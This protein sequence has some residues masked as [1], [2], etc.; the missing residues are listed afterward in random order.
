VTNWTI[1]KSDH[2]AVILTTEHKDKATTKNEHIK[3][4]N[5][6]VTNTEL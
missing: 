6:I 4:D 5:T 1:T 3:L 2:A